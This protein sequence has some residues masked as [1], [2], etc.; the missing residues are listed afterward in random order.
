MAKTYTA[1][2]MSPGGNSQCSAH[3][4][5]WRPRLPGGAS[6]SL[7]LD[8]RSRSILPMWTRRACRN[9]SAAA[10]RRLGRAEGRT[11]RPQVRRCSRHRGRYDRDGRRPGLGQA[12]G[13]RGR[14]AHAPHAV[15][16][17]AR[18]DH[19]RR[20]GGRRHG[21]HG[22][23]AERTL[24]TFVPFPKRRSLATSLQGNRWTRPALMPSRAAEHCSSPGSRDVTPMWWDCR[25][26]CCCGYYDH[27][28]WWCCNTPPS[29]RGV[30]HWE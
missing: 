7:R 28:E 10:G 25:S 23:D 2:V 14:Q 18:G 21:P 30:P 20:R 24:V 9:S 15:G 27:S 11:C 22:I 19:G 8:S 13:C 4:S 1:P 17:D 12:R 6:S 16:Q 5:S 3:P 29:L 26:S